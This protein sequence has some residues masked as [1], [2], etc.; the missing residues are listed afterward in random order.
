MV[1]SRRERLREATYEEI[2]SIARRQMAEQG[3]AAISLRGIAT[4]MGM[5]A[6]SLYNYYKSREDLI[7]ALIVEAFSSLAAT[8][9]TANQSRPTQD[10]GGRLNAAMLAYRDWAVTHPHDFDLI[11]GKPIGGYSAPE[12]ETLPPVRRISKVFFDIMVAAWQAGKLSVPPQYRQIPPD[13]YRQLQAWCN[14]DEGQGRVEPEVLHLILMLQSRGQGMIF[15]ELNH[16]LQWALS[17]PAAFYHFEVRAI[18][19]SLGLT[20]IE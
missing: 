11:Y 5:A 6:P 3:A 4:Q 1:L 7:T 14:S 18:I 10:Y 15:M 9:E 17:D 19:E 20:L 13:L 8:L 2:K 16:H 12:E